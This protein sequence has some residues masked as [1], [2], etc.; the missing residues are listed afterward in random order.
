MIVAVRAA[1]SGMSDR[2]EPQRWRALSRALT[3]I[4]A[5]SVIT[6]MVLS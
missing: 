3:T 4:R 5:C 2:L 1:S 6:M